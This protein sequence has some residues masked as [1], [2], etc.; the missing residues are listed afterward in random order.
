MPG[1]QYPQNVTFGETLKSAFDLGKTLP[2]PRRRKAVDVGRYK[3]ID[4]GL[5]GASKAPVSE[6]LTGL[7]TITTP[8]MSS[9]KFEG[10]HPGVDVAAPRGTPI[11]AFTGGTVTGARAGQKWTPS[12]PSFGNYLIIQDDKG[13]YH[14]YSH[15][16]EDWMPMQVGTKVEAGQQIGLMGKTGG[17]YSRSGG[18]PSHLDYRIYN[19]AKR[20]FQ[21]S[22]YLETIQ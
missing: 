16:H 22:A 11:P 13:N 1:P 18:D 9:T 12:Q 5:T 7:G 3:G 20:Y 10:R 2:R 8:Y 6:K 19:S 15:L 17:S 4:S 21:P 14:R